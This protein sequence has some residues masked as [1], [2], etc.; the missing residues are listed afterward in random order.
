MGT[1]NPF[2]GVT[3]ESLCIPCN[4][5]LVCSSEG[6][7]NNKPIGDNLAQIIN[8]FIKP[9]EAGLDSCLSVELQPLAGTDVK[10]SPRHQI[11]FE[12]SSSVKWHP[13][14][15]RAVLSV[16]SRWARRRSAPRGTCA[17][18]GHPL[19]PSS[20]PT[21]TS[22][23][24]A[25]PRR[26]SSQTCAPGVTTAPTVPLRPAASSSRAWLATTARREPGL[27]YPGAPR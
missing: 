5:G 27:S 15:W 25:P 26:A 20:A 21:D 19:R 1:W 18:P 16:P 6:T 2:R 24:T 11:H 4:P 3:D 23:A 7:Q 13:M 8:E 17:M 12:P 22:A 10:C 14:T 9:C